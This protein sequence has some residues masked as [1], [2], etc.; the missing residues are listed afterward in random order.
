MSTGSFLP[1]YIRF[2]LS[3][4][5]ISTRMS[6]ENEE[7]SRCAHEL[8]SPRCANLGPLPPEPPEPTDTSPPQP[9]NITYTFSFTQKLILAPSNWVS[10]CEPQDQSSV[11][12]AQ[13]NA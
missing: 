7:R 10:P 5:V 6:W 2:L 1:K 9:R 8:V 4:E 11:D 3:L 12:W 13:T